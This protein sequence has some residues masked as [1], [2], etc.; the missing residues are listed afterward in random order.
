MKPTAYQ[1][2]LT[3]RFYAE[4][5]CDPNL[6]AWDEHSRTDAIHLCM[7]LLGYI[8]YNG[9][10]IRPEDLKGH[11]YG[12][13]P[14]LTDRWE[15]ETKEVEAAVAAENTNSTSDGEPPTDTE[16]REAVLPED[17]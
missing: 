4:V 14:E 11:T 9:K 6:S 7:S 1:N 5:V 10:H 2:L 17:V 8:L 16:V 12:Q 15:S 3:R 13:V